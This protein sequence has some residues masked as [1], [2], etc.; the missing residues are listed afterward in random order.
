MDDLQNGYN[1]GR[2]LRSIFFKRGKKFDYVRRG[3]TFRQTRRNGDVE[4]A[5]VSAIYTDGHNIPHVRFN[6]VFEKAFRAAVKDG[7]RVLSLK[8]FFKQFPERVERSP[9][10]VPDAVLSQSAPQARAA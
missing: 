2:M 5:L 10:M 9:A 3:A 6:V 7:P 8:Q 4:T 1:H